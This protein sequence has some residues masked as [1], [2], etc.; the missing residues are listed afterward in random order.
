[1]GGVNEKYSERK[2]KHDNYNLRLS[3][4]KEK[5]KRCM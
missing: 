3:Y 4:K 1:M 2:I 5:E